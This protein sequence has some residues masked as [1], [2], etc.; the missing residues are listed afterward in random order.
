MGGRVVRKIAWTISGGRLM[1]AGR[2]FCLAISILSCRSA[3]AQS[4]LANDA[5]IPLTTTPA[6]VLPATQAGRSAILFQVLG[7]PAVAC[8]PGGSTPSF[9]GDSLMLAGGT[10]TPAIGGSA[11]LAGPLADPGVWLCVA[12]A[13]TATLMVK[14]YR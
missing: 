2:L 7:T 9:G 4:T 5:A 8:R 13:G 11:L 10:G 1:R 3:L 6:Q 14:A 12:Y